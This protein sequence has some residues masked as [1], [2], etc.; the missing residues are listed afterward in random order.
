MNTAH[1]KPNRDSRA[2]EKLALEHMDRLFATALRLTRSVPDAEDLVQETLVRSFAAFHRIDPDGN[3]KAYLFRVLTNIFINDYRHG[4]IVRNAGEMARVGL[5]DGTLYSSEC[6]KKWADPHVRFLH[7]NLSA[8]V[9][10]ALNAL[11]EKFRRVLVMSDLMEF[12][13]A[14]IS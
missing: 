4:K 10:D 12:T 1:E 6:Q 2:F 3:M 13:Y 8:A 7:S 5:L 9:T 11:P 14:Q